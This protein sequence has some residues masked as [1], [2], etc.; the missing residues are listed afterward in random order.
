M[1]YFG[2]SELMKNHGINAITSCM[3]WYFHTI[4]S[5]KLR[6]QTR[7]DLQRLFVETK[8][9]GK[10]TLRMLGLGMRSYYWIDLCV[11]PIRCSWR[12]NFCRRSSGKQLLVSGEKARTE[13]NGSV[14]CRVTTST[15]IERRPGPRGRGRQITPHRRGSRAAAA[16]LSLRLRRPAGRG[17]GAAVP[18]RGHVAWGA[19]RV[20]PRVPVCVLECT[21]CHG[22]ESDGTRNVNGEFLSDRH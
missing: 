18:G 19:S 17:P 2:F 3:R 5:K 12:S 14:A 1:K 13:S 16:G 21:E 15:E 8:E 6:C 7:P 11:A 4:V 10:D 9:I 22:R 20:V